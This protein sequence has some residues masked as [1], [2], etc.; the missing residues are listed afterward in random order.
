MIKPYDYLVVGAELYGATFSHQMIAFGKRVLVIDKRNEIGGNLRC[1]TINGIV[2]HKYGPHIFHTSQKWIWDYVNS[3]AEFRPFIYQPM[4]KYDGKLYNLPFNMNTFYQIWG[5]SDPSIVMQKI[6]NQASKIKSVN[7]LRDQ[8][9]SMVGEDVFE[10]LIRGYTEK[11]WG[12]KCEDLPASIIKRLPV[13]LTFDN[14]YFDDTY[15]GIPVGGYNGMISNQLRGA[16][17]VLGVDY[18]QHRDFYN[19]LADKIVFTGA[20]DAFYGYMFGHL[21]YRGLKFVNKVIDRDNYQGAPVINYTNGNIPFTRII[22]HKWFENSPQNSPNLTTVVTFEYPD[23]WE[24]GKDEFYPIND[25]KNNLLLSRYAGLAKVE[26]NVIFGGR[27]GSYRY[28]DMHQ[29]IAQAFADVKKE[30]AKL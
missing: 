24:P 11:Q 27:L 1:E 23:K 10:I 8:A 18:L 26:D 3:L 20:I 15:C 7:N 28:Y 6:K 9:I 2:C 16:K 12:R 4:A 22:E 5:L 19:R 21:E 17:V 14:N 25:A 29:V 13:R 30:K